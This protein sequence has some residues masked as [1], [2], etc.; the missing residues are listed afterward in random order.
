MELLDMKKIISEMKTTLYDIK[1]L[2]TAE[3]EISEHREMTIEFI[4]NEA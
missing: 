4:L 2:D 3:G 1:R